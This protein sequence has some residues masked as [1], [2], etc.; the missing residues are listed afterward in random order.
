MLVQ[1]AILSKNSTILLQMRPKMKLTDINISTL[2]L[3]KC[4]SSHDYKCNYENLPRPY[5]SVAIMLKGTCILHCQGE[6]T[7]I[8]PGD[9]FFIPQNCTYRSSWHIDNI[10]QEVTFFSMHF[11][12]DAPV[13]DFA[14]YKNKIQKLN[15]EDTSYLIKKFE[16]LQGYLLSSLENSFLPVSL[17]FEILSVVSS[18]MNTY[19]KGEL[20]EKI[21]PAIDYLQINFQSSVSIRYLASLCFLSESRFFTLFKRQTGMSPIKYKNYLKL[22]QIAQYLLL[23][24]DKSI[25]NI[26]DTFYFSSPVYLIRQFKKQFGKTPYQYRKDARPYKI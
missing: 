14:K 3:H 10:D 7:P 18:A 12:F 15:M 5:H 22:N 19:Q 8:Y 16:E 4:A 2:F 6:I 24:P 9:A 13:N 17:F 25:E 23:Y 26:S 1:Y 11:S 21:K 20:F